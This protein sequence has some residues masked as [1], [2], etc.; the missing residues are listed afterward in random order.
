MSNIYVCGPTIYNRLH[1]G[2]FRVV[3]FA[4]VY[5]KITGNTVY[6]NETDVDDKILNNTGGGENSFYSYIQFYR[7]YFRSWVKRLGLDKLVILSAIEHIPDMWEDVT[8]LLKNGHAIETTEGIYDVNNGFA[9]WKKSNYPPTWYGGRPGWHTQ[10]ATMVKKYECKIHMGGVDLKFPHHHN[11]TILLNYFNYRI[12]QWLHIEAV[13]VNSVK[14]SKS[15]KNYYYIEDIIPCADDYSIGFIKY[16]LLSV[17]YNKRIQLGSA[18]IQCKRQ[19]YLKLLSMWCKT[20]FTEID[21]N[22]IKTG[23]VLNK[24]LKSKD[25]TLLNYINEF[26]EIIPQL[27]TEVIFQIKK[28][29]FE[30]SNLR[31]K[32]E[33]VAADRIRDKLTAVGVS[34]YD[35]PTG[36][37]FS[38]NSTDS[39]YSLLR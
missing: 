17:D 13:T 38:I 39:L 3:I 27:H 28:L 32:S 29:I 10:C 37:N 30:R 23:T 6:I 1:L 21:V 24:I 26:Y 35:T 31:E 16:L 22:M 19:E 12:Q 20:N 11:E 33:F 34:L 2:N 36:V 15:L 4:N 25:F 7:T 18:A 9:I 5:G 8:Q 14:M